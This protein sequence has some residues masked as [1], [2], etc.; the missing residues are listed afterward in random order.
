MENEDKQEML[1]ADTDKKLEELKDF[2]STQNLAIEKLKNEVAKPKEKNG[3]V[4]KVN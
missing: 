2:L 4:P 3:L 1:V